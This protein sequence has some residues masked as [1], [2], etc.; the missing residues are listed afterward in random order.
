MFCTLLQRFFVFFFF[1]H[2]INYSNQLDFQTKIVRGKKKGLV[3][4]TFSREHNNGNVTLAW[5]RA[6][7]ISRNTSSRRTTVAK[8]RKTRRR[9]WPC[10]CTAQRRNSWPYSEREFFLSFSTLRFYNIKFSKSL[11]P[12]GADHVTACRKLFHTAISFTYRCNRRRNNSFVNYFCEIQKK[13]KR[14]PKNEPR[15]LDSVICTIRTSRWRRSLREKKI[16]FNFFFVELNFINLTLLTKLNLFE[17]NFVIIAHEE[18]RLNLPNR[19][20][21][22]FYVNYNV[23]Y[24]PSMCARDR[25]FTRCGVIR[26]FERK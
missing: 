10:R 23:V 8:L 19:T 9:T 2:I 17:L 11:R 20:R 22:S 1:F 6:S 5:P 3:C 18:S 15:C 16:T 24:M 7:W 12:V 4:F 13:K 25:C 21:I 26:L 14:F